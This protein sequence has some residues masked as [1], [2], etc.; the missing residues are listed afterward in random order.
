MPEDALLIYGG[1]SPA[2]IVLKPDV[3]GRTTISDRDSLNH[4]EA[5]TPLSSPKFE[6]SDLTQMIAV[7]RKATDESFF[8]TENFAKFGSIEA[9][10][11]GGIKLDDIGKVVFY[12]TPSEEMRDL[13]NSKG[14]IW[15]VSDKKPY[16]KPRAFG[17]MF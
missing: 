6:A 16:S 11:H 7:Y 4:F 2:Q 5:T 1:R 10:V 15:E 3:K 14:V 8:N 13:L 9:Q 17:G 12:D